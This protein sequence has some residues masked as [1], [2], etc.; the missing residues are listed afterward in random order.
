MNNSNGAEMLERLRPGEIVTIRLADGSTARGR[1][2]WHPLMPGAR[3]LF[4]GR[5]EREVTAA[6]IISVTP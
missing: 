3:W 6:N 1:C 4:D 5:A 2:R